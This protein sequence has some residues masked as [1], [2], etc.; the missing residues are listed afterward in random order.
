MAKTKTPTTPPPLSLRL[1]DELNN[2]LEAAMKATRLSKSDLARLSIERG[3]KIVLKQLA[4]PVE[5]AA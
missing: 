5:A 1:D 4:T 3:L 2:D